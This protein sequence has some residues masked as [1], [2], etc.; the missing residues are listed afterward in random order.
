ME[1][2]VYLRALELDDYKITIDWRKEDALWDNL[3]ICRRFVSSDT[4]RRWVEKSI[5]E[6]ESGEKLRFIICLK[7]ND[8][9]IGLFS[10]SNIDLINRK[11]SAS[12]IISKQYRKMGLA[13]EA[14]L[15][16][17]HH[18]FS[19]YGMERIEGKAIETNY[20]SITATKKFGF[21]EEGRLRNAI[22]K[23]GKFYDLIQFGLLKNEFYDLH[24]DKINSYNKKS[25]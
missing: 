20:A 5:L 23:F 2:H 25:H 3:V 18:M 22:F 19:D 7:E 24:G 1:F 17:Y 15:L 10:I 8:A 13:F 12:S 6:H 9:V 11:C 16:V 14:R 4:E 21:I